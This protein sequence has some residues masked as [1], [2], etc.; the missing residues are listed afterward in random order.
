MCCRDKLEPKP[1][2][3]Q[4]MLALDHLAAMYEQ[5]HTL[6][7][8]STR[9]GHWVNEAFVVRL[10]A[11]LEAHD[12]VDGVKSI[13]GS[14]PGSRRVDLCRRLRQKIAHATGRINDEDSRRLDREIRQEFRLGNQESLFS[15]TFILSK[16]T[17]LGPMYQA[18]RDDSLALLDAEAHGYVTDADLGGQAFT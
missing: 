3:P 11:V 17:V 16:D 9:A 6:Q 15:G 2:D 5:L 13:D 4:V 12:V 8:C 1:A 7:R 14:L 10:W 18:C